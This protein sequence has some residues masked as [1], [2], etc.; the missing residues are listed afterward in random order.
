MREIKFRGM[1]ISGEWCYGYLSVISTGRIDIERGSYISN[2]MGSPFAYQVRPETV[3]QFT[4][5]NDYN[6]IPIYEGDVVKGKRFAIRG[7]QV[8][9]IG[10]IVFVN[11][12]FKINGVGQYKGIIHEELHRGFEVIGN[13]HSNP[14]LLEATV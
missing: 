13:I 6:D 14:E 8:R 10:E 11:G 1:S 3:G 12:C 2:K 4:G 7:G 5:M 9:F